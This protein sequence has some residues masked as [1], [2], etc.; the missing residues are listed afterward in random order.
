MRDCSFNCIKC[1]CII[2][3]KRTFSFI[4]LITKVDY[5]VLIKVK[6]FKLMVGTTWIEADLF[7]FK[8]VDPWSFPDDC[9]GCYNVLITSSILNPLMQTH[10]TC[11]SYW[12]QSSSGYVSIQ[13]LKWFCRDYILWRKGCFTK[14]FKIWLIPQFL[15]LQT[16]CQH[17][18]SIDHDELL[19]RQF[20]L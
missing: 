3:E 16:Y 9:P 13:I 4:K 5:S 11:I 6:K 1:T 17:C 12:K 14:K 20:G 18:C 2:K 19:T 15:Y 8:K 10:Y 7:A